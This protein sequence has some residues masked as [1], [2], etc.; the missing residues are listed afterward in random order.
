MKVLLEDVL[1]NFRGRDD[2]YIGCWGAYF[3]RL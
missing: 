1:S 2:F 3:S